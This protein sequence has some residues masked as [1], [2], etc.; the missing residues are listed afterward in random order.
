MRVFHFINEH[1]GL[2]DLSKRRLKI[3]T[4]NEL[5]DPFEFFGINLGDKGLRHA[6]GVMKNEMALKR[7]LLCFSRAWHNPVLWSHY[8]DRHTGLCLGF[9][10]PDHLFQRI[11]YSRKRLI[12]EPQAFVTPPKFDDETLV[13]LFFTKYSHWRYE[14]EVR[15]FVTLEDRDPETDL[16]FTDFGDNLRLKM[17]IVGAQSAVSRATLQAALGDLAPFVETLK[18]RL[19]FKTFRVVRQRNTA[20]WA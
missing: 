16:Y 17:V 20:L 8:A 4:L 10:V 2:D 11:F 14:D 3:A 6:F 1:H 7:G 13:K 18:A 15:G 5:N 19:A 9:D 12:I